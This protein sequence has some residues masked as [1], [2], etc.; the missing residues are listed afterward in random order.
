MAARAVWLPLLLLLAVTNVHAERLPIRLYSTA[1]GLAHNTVRK[2]V[3]DSRGFLWFCTVDG[4]SRFDGSA[5]RTFNTEHGLPPA[6]IVDLLETKDGDIWVATVAGLVY[7]GRTSASAPRTVRPVDAPGGTPPL[8]VIVPEGGDRRS[9]WITVL[10]QTRDGTI[11]VGTGNGLFRLHQGANGPS[12]IAADIGLPPPAYP[13]LRIIADLLEDRH[14]TLWVGTP[15]GLYRRWTDGHVVRYTMRDGLPREYISDLL[16]DRDG[17]LWV[18]TRDSGFFAVDADGSRATPQFGRPFLSAE[19]LPSDWVTQLFES[20]DGR[21]WAATSQGV[22]ELL[23]AVNGGRRPLRALTSRQ[24]M[25]S[26]YIDAIGEDLNGNIWFG[27]ASSGAMKLS[28]DGFT[29][30]GRQDGIGDV[31]GVFPDRAGHICFRGLVL[32][33]GVKSV[34]EGGRVDLV[35]EKDPKLDYRF[36]CRRNDR[37]TWLVPGGLTSWGWVH[38]GVTLQTRDGEWWLGTHE[39]VLRYP[40]TADFTQLARTTPL[41]VYRTA[42][43]L[44]ANQIFLLFEDSRGDVWISSISSATRG[45]SRFER[46]TNRL[47]DMAGHPGLPSMVG[48]IVRSMAE[49]REGNVWLGFNDGVA[50]YTNGAFTFFTTVHGLPPGPFRSVHVDRS[51]RV[52]LASERSGLSRVD[53]PSSAAPTFVPYTAA[54]G[55]S[56]SS[57]TVVTEDREGFL[58]VGGGHGL[59]RFDPAQHRVRQFTATDGLVPGLIVGAHADTGG[60]LWFGTTN[61]LVR[62]T[63]PPAASTSPPPVLISALRIA[64]VPQP[65]SPFG[66]PQV[67]LGDLTPEHRQLEIEFVGLGFR[68]GEVMRYQY[69]LE[70]ADADWSTPTIRRTV[71]YA[72]LSSGTYAF[73]VRAVNA[74]GVASSEPAAIRFTVLPPLWQRWWFLAALLA[75]SGLAVHFAFRYRL[76]R[77]LEVANMRTHIATDLHDD[78]GANL[79]RIA[80]LSEVAQ[81]TRD[82]GPLVSIASIARESVAAMSDI[83]WAINPKRESLLDL[84]RRMREHADELF[85]QRAIQLRFT[86]PADDTRRLG[87]DVRRDVLLVFKEAVNNAARHSRCTAVAISLSL[88]VGWLVLRVEDNGTGFDPGDEDE[89]NG[90]TSMR[91]RAARL[92]GELRIEPLEPSGTRLTLS[93]PL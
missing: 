37:F 17:Q 5:F 14:G 2:I 21:F 31:F 53:D 18:G 7:F 38:E 81:R 1:D 91:R 8:P 45:L 59:D 72:R 16:E 49:D 12:L 86:A 40:A 80:L 55:L 51:G 23:P 76:R 44:A 87:V 50:R 29:T 30:Y 35:S 64:G 67:E 79:T 62:L 36:G 24:G 41:A 42:E 70:G 65:V 32:M 3:R 66:E 4:L 54:S 25:A 63:S 85:T 93:V 48:D 11:W 74:D 52:W 46:R 6:E 75:A 33:D 69:K 57:L 77:L 82:E 83:V 39:G 90:I 61:G 43:G 10:Y 19:G 47:H 13:E 27:S 88:D 71:T 15:V 22:A 9:R 68:L 60:A 84:T 28:R 20:S 26:G 56:S 89:G 92:R 73:R 78:I 58:Y 34:F